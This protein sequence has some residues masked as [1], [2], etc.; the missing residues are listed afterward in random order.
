MIIILTYSLCLVGW[1]GSFSVMRGFCLV[2]SQIQVTLCLNFVWFFCETEHVLNVP[3]YMVDD[4]VL[5]V[6][7][8]PSVC[9]CE[10][11]EDVC[12]FVFV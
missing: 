8:T 6:C 12:T 4:I 10:L 5:C 1:C 11:K 7:V 9:E 2:V 3:L